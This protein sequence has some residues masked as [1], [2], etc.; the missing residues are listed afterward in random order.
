MIL[1]TWFDR[2]TRAVNRTAP[3][4]RK[5]TEISYSDGLTGPSD[6]GRRY[7]AP[8]ARRPGRERAGR[9][10]RVAESAIGDR[11]GGA[12]RRRRPLVRHPRRV[13]DVHG[14]HHSQRRSFIQYH[15]D[16]NPVNA[17]YQGR[18]WERLYDPVRVSEAKMT[19]QSEQRAGRVDAE[20]VPSRHRL[21]VGQTRRRVFRPLDAISAVGR[22]SG[23][24]RGDHPRRDPLGKRDCRF[25]GVS[26]SALD[27]VGH[28]FGPEQPRSAG[29]SPVSTS[30]SANF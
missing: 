25:L 28:A 26:F 23:K 1:N 21:K 10:V 17:A 27:L 11:P 6:S 8:D 5:T 3:T 24:A 7:A 29:F 19:T 14:I 15:A 12:R 18:Q 9:V 16:R 22:I 2:K 4:T 20:D 30:R 13:C